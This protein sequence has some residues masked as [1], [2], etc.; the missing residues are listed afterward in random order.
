MGKLRTTRR[1]KAVFWLKSELERRGLK[2]CIFDG[3]QNKFIYG[4][5]RMEILN[6]TWFV[7][8]INSSGATDELSIRYFISGA[9]G[10]VVLSE[11]GLNKYP[12]KDGEHFVESTIKEMP[13]KICY[14]MNHPDEWQKISENMSQLLQNEL[15]LEKSLE[16][17]LS[18]VKYIP[19]NEMIN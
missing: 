16:K 18:N 1:K 19:E 14:Y 12:F 10:A 15:T 11:P 8:N 7:I 6:K 9:N 17:I 4:D 13:D 2:M 5:E 3:E